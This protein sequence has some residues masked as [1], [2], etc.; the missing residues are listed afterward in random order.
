MVF[1]RTY[2]ALAQRKFEEAWGRGDYEAAVRILDNMPF[3]R[4]IKEKLER[5]VV[6]VEG[7]K[8]IVQSK[9]DPAKIREL[10]GKIEELEAVIAAY[11]GMGSIEDL[12]DL[13][14]KLGEYEKLGSI[15]E[16][17]ERLRKL[18][19]YE[20]LGT[21]ERLEESLGE[22]DDFREIERDVLS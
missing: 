5:M 22:L 21:V 8:A 17:R 10:G 16:L 15:D 3:G 6:L 7:Y 1:S 18:E 13:R 2:Y 14:D 11:R 9:L 20:G 4:D 19:K 12:Q